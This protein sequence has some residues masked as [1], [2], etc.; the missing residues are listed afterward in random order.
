M[1]A[2]TTTAPTLTFNQARAIFAEKARE[3]DAHSSRNIQH[4]VCDD[5]TVWSCEMDVGPE[6]GD[7]E[8]VLVTFSDHWSDGIE[9]HWDTLTTEP[10]G[11]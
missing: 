7:F 10:C 8:W 1:A 2:I 5:V 4:E 6:D 11:E 3:V 9:V